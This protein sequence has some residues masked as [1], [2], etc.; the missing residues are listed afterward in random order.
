[1]QSLTAEQRLTSPSINCMACMPDMCNGCRQRHTLLA[2]AKKTHEPS[3]RGEGWEIE[4]PASSTRG[5]A[6]EEQLTSQVEQDAEA[7]LAG[8]EAEQLPETCMCP[9]LASCHNT[10][11]S[12]TQNDSQVL[13]LRGSLAPTT[14]QA[15]LPWPMLSVEKCCS[16]NFSFIK[17][18][19]RMQH[20]ARCYSSRRRQ[21]MSQQKGGGESMLKSTYKR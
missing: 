5:D 2:A 19:F 1:M 17:P 10:C 12:H 11:W 9:L 20:R 18:R 16:S 8:E 6:L 21:Y 7:S 4:A 14:H 15:K 3:E 13:A